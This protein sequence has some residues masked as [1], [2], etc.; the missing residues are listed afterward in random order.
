MSHVAS[1]KSYFKNMLQ[2]R[3]DQVKKIMFIFSNEESE[4]CVL[5]KNTQFLQ[6]I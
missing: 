4:I 2:E 6:F 5:I 3:H 1:F